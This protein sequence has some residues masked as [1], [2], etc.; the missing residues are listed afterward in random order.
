[1]NEAYRRF[2]VVIRVDPQDLGPAVKLMMTKLEGLALGETRLAFSS[3][4]GETF[5]VFMKS[6]KAAGLI[7]ATLTNQYIKGDKTFVM[8]TEV[9]EEWG[10]AGN[11]RGWEWLQHH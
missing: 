7:S 4:K 5:G 10:G 9:G 1:M 11:S 2:L 3:L 6:R 8:V